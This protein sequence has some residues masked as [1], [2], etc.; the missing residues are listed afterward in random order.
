M[1][2]SSP[3]L[4][5]TVL[6]GFLGAG[7]TTWLRHH[8]RSGV[9]R[10]AILIV[11]EAA[12]AAIDHVL[13]GSAD[14][15]HVLAGGC[16]CCNGMPKLLRLLRGL[17]ASSPVAETSAI[18]RVVLETSGLSDPLVIREAIESD[19][20]LST[21]VEVSEI[22]VIIDAV[23]GR[24]LLRSEPLVGRQVASAD[25]VIISKTDAAV[26]SDVAQLLDAL[27]R[28]NPDAAR[29]GAVRGVEVALPD[30]E[31][32]DSTESEETWPDRDAGAPLASEIRLGDTTWPV[33]AVWLSALLRAHGAHLL[34]VKGVVRTPTG[35]LL[36][37]AV[38]GYVQPPER[39]PS[40]MDDAD[41]TLV[42]FSRGPSAESLQRSLDAFAKAAREPSRRC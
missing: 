17:L 26:P 6:N 10:D 28:L 14:R 39:L 32:S 27:H 20:C 41:G 5:L 38:R 29:F 19:P 22:I 23:N 8:L 21:C 37:Q 1:R 16:A 36:I 24:D 42:V 9:F 7:K 30:T 13:L 12:S 2:C 40:A 18:Q 35:R 11:N 34:R 3:R 31:T 33:F 25:C 15:V 4:R